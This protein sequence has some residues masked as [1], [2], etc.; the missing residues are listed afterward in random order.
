M[1]FLKHYTGLSDEKLIA[2]FQTNYAYQMFCGCRLK[3]G[4]ETYDNAFVNRK[5]SFNFS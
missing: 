4:E 3:V 2:T 5:F 1:M